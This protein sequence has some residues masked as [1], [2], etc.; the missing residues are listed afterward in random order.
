MICYDNMQLIWQGVYMVSEQKCS[1]QNI[2]AHW[3]KI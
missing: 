2:A 1:L 3:L